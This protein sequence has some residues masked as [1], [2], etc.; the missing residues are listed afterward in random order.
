MIIVTA[1]ASVILGNVVWWWGVGL[2][3]VVLHFFLFCNIVRMARPLELVWAAIF[4]SLAAMT[5]TMNTPS[6]LATF[7][8]SFLVTPIVVALEMRK[9]SYHG[10]A[11]QTINPNLPNWWNDYIVVSPPVSTDSVAS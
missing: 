6:P 3:F 1:I 9:S 8:L 7:G 4:T 11:W 2:A 5:V 10:I